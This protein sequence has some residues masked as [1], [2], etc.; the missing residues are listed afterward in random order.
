MLSTTS[1]HMTETTFRAAP[2][3]VTLLVNFVIFVLERELFVHSETPIGLSCMHVYQVPF[4]SSS[5]L[6]K[7]LIL[8]DRILQSA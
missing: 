5:T 4:S 7:T 6:S 8:T 2:P 3:D 1:T